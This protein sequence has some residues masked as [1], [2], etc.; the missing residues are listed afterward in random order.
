M[1][2]GTDFRSLYDRDYWGSWDLDAGDKT[3]QITKCIGGQL[4][5]MGGRKSR[6][7]VIYVD[8]SDKG[9]ALNKT[10][11]KTIAALYGNH[12]EQWT[13]K[14]ITL[15]KAKT[16]NPNGGGEIDCIRVRPEAPTPAQQK[17][18]PRLVSNK[19]SL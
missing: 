5:G 13:G 9:I 6:K 18:A 10:N 2:T 12:V 19:D 1:T 11:G 4:T 7:P 17:A 16:N 14:W 3:V 8:G 15:Y